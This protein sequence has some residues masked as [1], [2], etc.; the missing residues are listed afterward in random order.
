MALYKHQVGRFMYLWTREK[1]PAQT[2]NHVVISAHGLFSLVNG[3]ETCQSNVKLH[4]YCPHGTSLEDPKLELIM[5]G[6]VKA[7][8]PPVAPKSS[9]DYE[10]AKYTNSDDNSTRHNTKNTE[11]YKTIG[12]LDTVFANKVADAK[13]IAGLTVASARQ[14]RQ[15]AFM[16]AGYSKW[17]DIITIRH[18]WKG[19]PG[20]F[21]KGPKLSSILKELDAAGYRYTDV[22]C[23]FCRAINADSPSSKP[24]NLFDAIL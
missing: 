5:A 11:T 15:A 19:L 18:R 9:Q 2:T 4:F 14:K 13:M 23:S 10:L 17:M 7:S 12:A 6:Q 1:V 3:M 21:G 8:G 20:F 16:E 22:H 24:E